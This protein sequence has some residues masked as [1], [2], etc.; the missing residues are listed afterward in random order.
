MHRIKSAV[1]VTFGSMLALGAQADL[2]GTDAIPAEQMIS[3]IEAAVAAHPGNVAEVEVDEENDR[4]IV[5]IEIVDAQG[6]KK[7]VEVDAE[8]SKVKEM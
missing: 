1:A 2:L 3:A 8:T 7:E 4:M 6:S 5:E